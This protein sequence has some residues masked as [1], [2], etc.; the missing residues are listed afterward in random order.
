[1]GWHIGDYAG[2]DWYKN[3]GVAGVDD[4][5]IRLDAR[6]EGSVRIAL[7]VP[8][9][10]VPVRTDLY[11]IVSDANRQSISLAGSTVVHAAA[12]YIAG[13]T[14]RDYYWQPRRAQ[15]IEV[16][17]VRP[18]GERVAGVATQATIIRLQSRYNHA[19]GTTT[20]IVD[21]LAT[22]RVETRTEPV[23]CP[24]IPPSAGQYHVVLTARD[25][26]GRSMRTSFER[27][28][29]GGGWSMDTRNEP[30]RIAVMA[31][32]PR[33]S[34]GDTATIIISSPFRSVEA[35]LT[36]ERE[37]VLESRRMRLD[38]GTTT[39]KVPI[40]EALAPNAFVSV[41]LVRGRSAAPGPPDDPG[42]PTVRAGYA[43]LHVATDNKRL[44]VQV[45][46][47]QQ[48]YRPGDTARVRVAVK[49]PTGRGH[50]AEVTLWAVDEGVLA[51]TGYTVPDPVDLM[52]QPRG[53][54]MRST[55]NLTSVVAQVP[56][57]W[58]GADSAGVP[59]YRPDYEEG[60]LSLESVVVASTASVQAA[61]PPPRPGN[62]TL[63]SNFQSTAF[64]IG[65]VVTDENGNGVAAAKLPDNLTTFRIMAVAVTAGDRYGSGSSS[66]LVSRP[67]LARPSLPRFLRDGDRFLAGVVVNQRT[68][69]VQH[70]VVEASA[71]GADL[72]GAGSKAD[73]LHGAAGRE[74]R[75]EFRALPGELASFQFGVRG[76]SDADAVALNVPVRPSYHPL[77]QTNAGM[78]RDTA[79]AEFRV[80]PG[81]DPVRS[82]L[83]VNFGSSVLSIILGVRNTLR[84]YPYACTEQVSSM[85]MPLIALYRAQKELGIDIGTG[86]RLRDEIE[87]A[88]RT[89]SWRQQPDGAIGYWG[90]YSWSTPGVTAHAARVLLEAREAGFR[91]DNTMLDRIAG[92]L[93]RH[94]RANEKPRFA[95]NFGYDERLLNAS[96]R[97]AAADVLSR[98]GRAEVPAEE[99][100]LAQLKDLHWEDRV[101][102]A[103]VLAR[104]GA[105]TPARDL[106]RQAWNGVLPEGRIL[107]LPAGS[108]HYVHSN[109]R[110]AAR[111]LSATLAIQPE[112][113]RVGL[114]VETLIQQGRSLGRMMWNTHDYASVVLALLP[115][116]RQRR[117][118]FAQAQASIEV[119][120][121]NGVLVTRVLRSGEPGDTSI[122]LAGLAQDAPVRLSL[123]SRN[124][125][126]PVFYYLTLR[127]VPRTRPVK[128]VDNGIFVER[129]YE[130][131]DTRAPVTG[132]AAGELVRVRLRVT[133]PAQRH[134]V[135]VD[136]PLPAG[137]EVVDPSLL[138][139]APGETMVQQRDA[140]PEPNEPG[141][142]FGRWY[143]GQ[144]S[145]FDHK[146]LRDDRVVHF[147]TVLWQGTWTASYLA[148][149]TTAGTFVMPP[150]HA[151]EMYN[152][153]VN[154]RTGGGVFTVR[155]Q[156]HN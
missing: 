74:V 18:D 82:T 122:A 26:Q 149:A 115:Y 8:P 91:V 25:A 37:R 30:F 102:L 63:R 50:R 107:T 90:P 6:G 119:R 100:L 130:R 65:S 146:E 31:D 80:D 33:Y 21:T 129:W 43:Q 142:H 67:L 17:A 135:V 154:G 123:R 151:E 23:S 72:I 111:L 133:V 42:R 114:L 131:V 83:E 11:A 5:A 19:A 101:L 95:A 7:P 66:M 137:L 2:T 87:A 104:R 49:E 78:L 4:G 69:G 56:E 60:A 9:N 54:G 36:V 38:S 117:Q 81:I 118:M 147:A 125:A 77:A 132:A 150:A 99:T 58:R 3:P 110:P 68:E 34:V 14:G 148:R 41:L 29:F 153:A 35:W 40:T 22:C 155:D 44:D 127:E 47:L 156:K 134:F 97:L 92:Y 51:L 27:W 93:S 96:E 89:L 121:P 108:N 143:W 64:F 70:V 12:L 98:L 136:D 57:R 62:N 46:P 13:R 152:P 88:I 76:R 113:P 138:T 16:I 10:G 20:E 53:A 24:F 109:T 55:S 103:E 94:L 141:W 75:F 52:Y 48:E 145:A 116:E 105:L 39:V 144:W 71:R 120:G 84:V 15:T 112:N 59:V 28:A 86:M 128:P 73:T 124:P 126:V 85:A 1:V 61:P 45:A 139:E 32:R 79:N 106:L 140:D